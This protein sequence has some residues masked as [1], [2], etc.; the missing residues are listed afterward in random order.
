M[1]FPLHALQ[2]K[3]ILLFKKFS[4]RF[5]Q[6]INCIHIHKEAEPMRFSLGGRSVRE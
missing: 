3:E 1:I 4:F 2:M 5:N 6:A